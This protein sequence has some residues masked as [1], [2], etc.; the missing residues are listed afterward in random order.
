MSRTELNRLSVCELSTYRWGFEDDVFHYSKLGFGAIGVWRYKLDEYGEAKGVELVRECG[1]KVSS[2]HW[3]G[4]FTGSDGRSYRDAIL[5]GLDAVD[6]AA[7]L[8][9]A[10]LVVLTG[11]RGGHTQSHAK[12][13]LRDSL[14]ELAEA[15]QALNVNL[16]VE[17][18][19]VGCADKWTSLTD[20]P[21]TL[22]LVA[23]VQSPNVGIVFDAYHLTH[24]QRILHWLPSLVPSIRLV[25]LGDAKEAPILEQNRCLLGEGKLPLNEVVRTLEANHYTGFYE[26]EIVGEHVEHFDYEYLLGH[27]SNQW[28]DWYEQAYRRP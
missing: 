15:A 22:D 24:D 26:L 5:D 28:L 10:C 21:M 23:E 1:L 27:A 6:L 12:R 20:L 11:S 9:A 13:I 7:E 18:M 8:G 3:A 14:R 19:H 17:P 2:L 4:G 16:A 25:Q